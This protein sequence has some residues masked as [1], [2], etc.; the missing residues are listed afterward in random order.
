M[1]G[2]LT[3]SAGLIKMAAYAKLY[4]NEKWNH[5][6]IILGSCKKSVNMYFQK[7]SVLVCNLTH[8]ELTQIGKSKFITSMYEQ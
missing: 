7:L 1:W 8:A 6:K 3:K 5:S 2:V 4:I